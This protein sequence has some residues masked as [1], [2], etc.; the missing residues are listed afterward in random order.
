MIDDGYCDC[1]NGI[2]EPGTSACAGHGVSNDPAVHAN[3][4]FCPNQGAKSKY[5]YSSTVGDAVCDCCDGSDEKPGLCTNTCS[6]EGHEY[7]ARQ[8]RM[9]RDRQTA[10]KVVKVYTSILLRY[11]DHGITLKLL[12]HSEYHIHQV[13]WLSIIVHSANSHRFDTTGARGG[14]AAAIGGLL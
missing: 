10:L 3:L 7:R 9:A 6:A 14:G 4:F 13:Y 5:I 8:E 11:S 12:C 1:V 2:D